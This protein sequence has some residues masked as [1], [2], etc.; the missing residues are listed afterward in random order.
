M[1]EVWSAASEDVWT[2]FVER[3]ARGSLSSGILT[4]SIENGG[5]RETDGATQDGNQCQHGRDAHAPLAVASHT[6]SFQIRIS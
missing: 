4:L 5:L 1:I 2:K 3:L 6:H